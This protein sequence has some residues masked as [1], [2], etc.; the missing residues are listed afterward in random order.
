[1]Q[2]LITM[3]PSEAVRSSELYA[4]LQAH[5]ELE[6]D[7]ALGGSLL[8]LLLS[9]D[10]VNRFDPEDDV[11]NQVLREASALEHDLMN[12]GVLGSDFRFIVARP[13]PLN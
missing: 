7:V 3:D 4:L 10:R 11:H 1:V 6:H 5:F 9:G 12:S 8:N 13:R 2:D